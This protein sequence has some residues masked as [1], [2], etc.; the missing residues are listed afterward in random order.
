MDA[1]LLYILLA[2]AGLVLGVFLGLVLGKRMIESRQGNL[3][4]EGKKLI[5]DA[6]REAERIKKEASL[7]S[8]DQ[9][10]EVRHEAEKEVR[11]RKADLIEEEKRLSNKLDQ[12][13][14]KIDILDKGRWNSSTRRRAL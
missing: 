2:A 3:E 14:R 4:R 1:I 12:I 6:L 11:A 5:E 7:Q 10:L 8:K 9:A 13:E